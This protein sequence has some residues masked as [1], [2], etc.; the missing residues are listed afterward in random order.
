MNTF[1]RVIV[2]I[3]AAWLF[4][5]LTTLIHEMGHM[6][7]YI[8]CA[9]KK[10]VAWHITVGIGTQLLKTK[11]LTIC[12]VPFFNGYFQLADTA[13]LTKKEALVMLSGGP[14]ASLLMTIVL[15]VSCNSIFTDQAIIF[16]MYC[17]FSQFLFTIIP[18]RYPSWIW[19]GAKSD[20]LQML[21][22][23]KKSK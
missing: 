21:Q 16:A 11:R 23:M 1:V 2:T 12:I 8:I 20:G 19:S 9:G 22:L 14:I 4:F 3:I 5:F 10:A 7:G 13:S 15:L 6:L 18:V 17:N